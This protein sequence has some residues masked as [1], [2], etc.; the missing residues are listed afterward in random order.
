[1]SSDIQR[2]ELQD[3]SITVADLKTGI[4]RSNASNSNED[5]VRIVM[6]KSS[7]Y[8]PA[9]EAV[10][11]SMNGEKL[12]EGAMDTQEYRTVVVRALLKKKSPPLVWMGGLNV[13][14]IR[15]AMFSMFLPFGSLDGTILLI[16]RL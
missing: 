8:D 3:F 5:R 11:S 13:W 16:I 1:M 14:L 7:L 4:M 9:R 2:L 12:A 10:E 6:P 15:I